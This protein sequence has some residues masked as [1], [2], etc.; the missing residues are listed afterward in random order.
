MFG[1]RAA[2]RAAGA[3]GDEEPLEDEAALDAAKHAVPPPPLP[4][5]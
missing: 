5:Y 1:E 2:L 3:A 4:S